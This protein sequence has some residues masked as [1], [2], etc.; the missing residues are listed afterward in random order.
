MEYQTWV[1]CPN[2]TEMSVRCVSMASWRSVSIEQ[3]KSQ[4]GH[5]TQGTSLISSGTKAP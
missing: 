3:H 5:C 2:I 4:I 1:S